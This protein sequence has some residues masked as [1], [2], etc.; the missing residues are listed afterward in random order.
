MLEVGKINTLEVV[1]ETEFGVYLAGNDQ[2]KEILLPL[3]Y[4]PKNCAKHRIQHH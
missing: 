2:Y 4:V 3:K 1:K